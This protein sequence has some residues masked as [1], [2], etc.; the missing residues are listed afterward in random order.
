[1]LNYI[2]DLTA[3]GL[4]PYNGGVAFFGFTP[5]TGGKN[6]NDKMNEND[7]TLLNAV[8]VAPSGE[9]VGPATSEGKILHGINNYP[10]INYEVK[11][12]NNDEYLEGTGADDEHPGLSGYDKADGQV[13]GCFNHES[14]DAEGAKMASTG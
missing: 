9:T 7:F 4:T 14:Q 12:L 2:L 1:M 6:A 3:T 13:G 8:G 10:A 11:E 5:E